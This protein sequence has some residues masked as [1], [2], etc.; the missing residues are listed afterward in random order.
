MAGTVRW[1][2]H[3]VSQLEDAVIVYSGMAVSDKQRRSSGVA[4]IF[5]ERAAAAWREAGSVCDPVS[6]RKK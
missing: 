1:P 2:G 5:S 4:V 6:D 3:G